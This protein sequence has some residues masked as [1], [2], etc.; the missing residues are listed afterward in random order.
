MECG[1]RLVSTMTAFSWPMLMSRSSQGAPDGR[2]SDSSWRMDSVQRATNACVWVVV[3]NVLLWGDIPNPATA[4]AGTY[5]TE[6]Y[7]F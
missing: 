2:P 3:T 7:T 1:P 6:S 4:P 5:F